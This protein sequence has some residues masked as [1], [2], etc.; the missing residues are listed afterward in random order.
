[1]GSYFPD[2]GSNP[3]PLHRDQTRIPCIGRQMLNHWTIRDVPPKLTL[4]SWPLNNT[5]LNC[6]G[7]L[8]HGFPA[9]PTVNT[10]VLY[11]L[12]LVEFLY[13]PSHTFRLYFYLL[14]TR[15]IREK[16]FWHEVYIKLEFWRARTEA[17]RN[18][19]LLF[20][21]SHCGLQNKVA[22]GW[23]ANL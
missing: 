2:L 4:Y 22:L 13:F 10:M 6:K 8:I 17:R 5:G 15:I 23:L 14:E 1:M 19:L 12:W 7:I 3:H 9:P 11:I 18:F 20:M 16:H 21:R